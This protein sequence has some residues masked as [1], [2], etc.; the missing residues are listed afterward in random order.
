MAYVQE[1]DLSAYAEWQAFPIIPCNLCGAQAN[2]KRRETKLML[3][4]WEKQF[5]GRVDAIFS[6][7]ARVTP[8]H[9]MDRHQFDFLGLA[10]QGSAQ[11]DGDLAFDPDPTLAEQAGTTP[12]QG[13]SVVSASR[14]ECA[15]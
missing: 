12:I 5:P 3:R 2:L 8:S 7:L 13:I 1:A 15:S 9:L 6:A 10:P 14:S 11:P 4:A